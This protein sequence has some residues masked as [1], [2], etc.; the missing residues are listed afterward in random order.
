MF[1]Y[2]NY[3]HQVSYGCLL[4]WV[5]HF[6]DKWESG[7]VGRWDIRRAGGS[8]ILEIRRTVYNTQSI[9]FT[10]TREPIQQ[11]LPRGRRLNL[12]NGPSM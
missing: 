3:S 1:S 10:F 9:T 5:S 11:K 7:I 2:F 8:C 4:I 6:L 12:T